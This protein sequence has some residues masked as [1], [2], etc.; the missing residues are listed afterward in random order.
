MMRRVNP[1]SLMVA[2]CWDDS[3]EWLTGGDMFDSTM[4]YVLS[5]NMWKRFAHGSI[6]LPAFDAAVNGAAMLYPQRTQDVLW[7]FLGS[8]DTQRML[9]RAGGDVR[10]LHGASFFQF[11]FMGAPIIYYGDELAMEGGADPDN[12]R[13]MR[14]DNVENNQTRAHF[15]KLARLRA[16]HEALRVGAFRT[17]LAENSGLYAY[18][19]YT[20][21]ERLLCVLNT[22]HEDVTAQLPLPEPLR[23]Q[24]AVRD[25]YGERTLPVWRGL[26]EVALKPGEGMVLK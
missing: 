12:R 16:S 26:V 9:T 5:R 18:Q 7:T 22:G 25:L 2:E 19:R 13:P 10:M 4:H 11:T 14:W 3:R 17:H 6:S 15:Q 23:A 1:D 8:H 21:G 20:D 24:A